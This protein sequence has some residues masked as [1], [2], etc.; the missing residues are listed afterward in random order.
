MGELR[1]RLANETAKL[2]G[3]VNWT[4]NHVCSVEDRKAIMQLDNYATECNDLICSICLMQQEISNYVRHSTHVK[5]FYWM[6]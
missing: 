2:R 6:T 3:A 4:I 5:T 1:E